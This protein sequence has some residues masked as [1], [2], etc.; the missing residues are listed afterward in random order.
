MTSYKKEDNTFTRSGLGG[1]PG[2][3][4]GLKR[5]KGGNVGGGGTILEAYPQDN[6]TG[7]S[8]K[9]ETVDSS[10]MKGSVTNLSHS[11]EGASAVP[12]QRGKV[13]RSGI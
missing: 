6:I 11:L 8:L 4:N 9:D 5:S 1:R 2:E 10:P 3:S 13:E 12:R 7:V